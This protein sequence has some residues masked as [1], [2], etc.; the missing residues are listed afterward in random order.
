MKHLL[1][2]L[3]A[4]PACLF[5]Q[6]PLP[7]AWYGNW[8][9]R[10]HIFNVQKQVAELDMQLLISS[11][12]SAH[13]AKWTILYL[14]D[15]SSGM[16]P[17][18][19]REYEIIGLSDQPGHFVIDEKNSILLDAYLLDQSLVSRFRVDNALLTVV[20]TLQGDSMRFEI[21]SGAYEALRDTG[22]EVKTVDAVQAFAISNYQRAQLYRQED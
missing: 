3:W 4:L 18:D 17:N 14:P 20:Y 13:R 8:E 9:G 15:D 5:A 22:E 12:D 2:L 10:L 21:F 6:N 1:W 11:T 19:R 7:E 16:K